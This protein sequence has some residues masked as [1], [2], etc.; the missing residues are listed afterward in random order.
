MCVIERRRSRRSRE[1]HWINHWTIC[2]LSR[3]DEAA[4]LER[5]IEY[6][7]LICMFQRITLCHLC[8]I[9]PHFS[10]RIYRNLFPEEL[11]KESL[12]LGKYLFYKK[13][14]RKRARFDTSDTELFFE[15]Y[16][17]FNDIQ[18]FS[19]ERRLRRLSITHILF[20][21][22]FNDSL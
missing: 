22:L 15:T 9:L 18:W 16:I 10:K 2:V 19:L 8:Q 20:N 7:W 4:V 1:N 5:I 3:G 11:F 14:L 17:L 12:E 13:V 6:H 21:D